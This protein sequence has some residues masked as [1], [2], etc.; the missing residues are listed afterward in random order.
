MATITPV[1]KQI[2]QDWF[3]TVSIIWY[4][5]PP[6]MEILFAIGTTL[7][8]SVAHLQYKLVGLIL[9]LFKNLAPPQKIGE[10]QV[11]SRA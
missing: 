11:G 10:T 7:I 8:Q 5:K 1:D 3:I 9:P 2:Y 4:K 6:C